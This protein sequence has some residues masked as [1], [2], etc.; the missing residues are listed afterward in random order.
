MNQKKSNPFV[1]IVVIAAMLILVVVA[2]I[3]CANGATL[4]ETAWSLVPPLIAIV[5]A[6]VTKEAYS[7]LFIGVV[8][9]ALFT[10]NFHPV[11][12]LD[13]V[14]N[15]GLISAIAVR[16]VRMNASCVIMA[17]SSKTRPML[18]N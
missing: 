17:G 11:A 1:S 14:V 12:T 8:V 18:W 13:T 5:L 6:L 15:T 16:T 7:S 10:T 2:G 9:G 3:R 4:A